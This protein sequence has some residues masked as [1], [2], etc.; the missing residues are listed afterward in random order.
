VY[1]VD[2]HHR[3]WN[4]ALQDELVKVLP[5]AVTAGRL[6]N[7]VYIDMDQAIIQGLNAGRKIVRRLTGREDE[8]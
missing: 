3:R 1:D 6:A 8:G 2:G 7:Y 4:K 5:T